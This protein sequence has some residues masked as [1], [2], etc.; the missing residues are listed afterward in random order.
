MCNLY[1]MTSTQ[2]AVRRLFDVDDPQQPNLP[3]QR[4]IFPGQ[5]APV[6][7][8]GAA[9]RQL[10]MMHWGFILPQQDKAPKD[11]NNARQDKV[12]QSRFWR[13]SFERR[14]CL[15][16][17]TS[18]AEPKG[19]RPAVWHWFALKG[20]EPRPLFAFAG[21][22]RSWRGQYRGEAVEMDCFAIL[23]TEPNEV[24]APV[25]PTR[26]PVMLAPDDYG[27]WLSGT[28][29]AAHALT[30]PYP[31]DAMHDVYQGDKEDS[32]DAGRTMGTLF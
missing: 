22:W 20:E 26:M 24:V 27:T 32:G 12:L 16:P 15:V 3:L 29:E 8:R 25:H 18:F 5:D 2:D 28:T 31:A 9:G 30:R 21:I 7:R 1:S 10:A 6:V 13:D 11:V 23:T 4:A 19:R 17:A 14:R